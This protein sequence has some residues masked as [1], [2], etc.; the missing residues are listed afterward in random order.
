MTKEQLREEA[1]KTVEAL[2]DQP[3]ADTVGILIDRGLLKE[4]RLLYQIEYVSDGPEWVFDTPTF[5]KRKMI[6]V[7]CTDCGR[8]AYFEY[9]KDPNK[10]HYG[11][12]NDN[13]EKINE[14]N[15]TICPFCGAEVRAIRATSFRGT[16]TIGECAYPV[17]LHN[18]NGHLCVLEWCVAK[19]TDRDGNVRYKTYKNEAIIVVRDKLFRAVGWFNNM[20]YL[21]RL[22]GWEPRCCYSE[23]IVGVKANCVMPVNKDAVYG[24]DAANSAIDEYLTGEAHDDYYYPGFYLKL[25]LKYP[26]VE[27]LVRSGLSAIV[28]DV[29]DDCTVEGG[30]YYNV[31]YS[32]NIEQTKT[33]IDWKKKKPHEMLRVEKEEIPTLKKIGIYK[34]PIYSLARAQHERPDVDTLIKLDKNEAGRAYWLAKEYNISA[35][36]MINYLIKGN[37]AKMLSDY[38]GMLQYV[39]GEIPESM[40]FPKDL[41]Q[42]HDRVMKLKQEK[43]D[44]LTNK[45]IENRAK[46]LKW[47]IYAADGLMIVLP[48]SQKDFIREGKKLNHCV[49]RYAKTHA[50]GT[51][52]I[53]FVRREE[54]PNEPFYTLEY[55]GKEIVQDHGKNNKLQTPEVL[56]FEA[57]WLSYI[58][59]GLN[60]GKRSTDN[61]KQRAGA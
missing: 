40:R 29:L 46:R 30:Y 15:D 53:L 23:H 31:N 28:G 18:V 24:S 19:H 36:R 61:T 56:A 47:A 58:K 50:E 60:N 54:K 57:K 17:T 52:T 11:F 33:F 43:G 26:N 12:I 51:T 45:N 6:R 4:E 3:P 37:N 14:G 48:K 44:E 55:N 9:Y 16:L 39:Y 20:G 59:G 1:F 7:T 49:A 41:K 13:G 21:T 42:Q 35:V 25:W 5:P 10:T 8:S 2:P 38:W 27:N 22:A 34:L 32:L